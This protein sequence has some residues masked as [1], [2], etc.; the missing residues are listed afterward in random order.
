MRR[1]ART[2]FV[3]RRYTKT[4]VLACVAA[5]LLGALIMH[6]LTPGQSMFGKNVTTTYTIII[7]FIAAN[8]LM[9]LIGMLIC[10]QVIKEALIKA[11]KSQANRRR[12]RKRPI[13]DHI[14]G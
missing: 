6:G 12:Y 9:G 1:S 14:G 11:S 3:M 4:A 8:I 2:G 10:R 5:V 7:G 13:K